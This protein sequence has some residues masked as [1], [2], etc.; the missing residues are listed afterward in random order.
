MVVGEY[1]DGL[2][3]WLMEAKRGK[4]FNLF[5]REI[6]ERQ[7]AM[8]Q[9]ALGKGDTEHEKGQAEVLNWVLNLPDNVIEAAAAKK[10]PES[11]KEDV[12]PEEKPGR[13]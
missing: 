7:Q 9:Q 13:E 5:M 2:A 3:E 12:R 8:N 10:S 11:E 1:P 4:Y 6:E